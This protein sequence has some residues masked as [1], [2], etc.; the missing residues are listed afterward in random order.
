MSYDISASK[1]TDYG[2]KD[3]DSI[4]ETFWEL[5]PQE[6]VKADSGVYIPI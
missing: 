2:E 6:T 3:R 4:P 1:E 5:S